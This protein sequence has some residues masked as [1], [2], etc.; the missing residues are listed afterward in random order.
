MTLTKQNARLHADARSEAMYAECQNPTSMPEKKIRACAGWV[1]KD[2]FFLQLTIDDSLVVVSRNQSAYWLPYELHV[3]SPF[4]PVGMAALQ[5]LNRLKDKK[6]VERLVVQL[7]TWTEETASEF[8]SPGGLSEV[9]FGPTAAHA[10]AEELSLWLLDGTRVVVTHPNAPIVEPTAT[11]KPGYGLRD[12]VAT[13]DLEQLDRLSFPEDGPVVIT[14][15]AGT[16]KTTVALYRARYLLEAQRRLSAANPGAPVFFRERECLVVLRKE[17][18]VPYIRELAGELMIPEVNV[19]SFDNWFRREVFRRYYRG[20]DKAQRYT[21]EPRLNWARW[22]VPIDRQTIE[23]FVAA[24]L[25]PPLHSTTKGLKVALVKEID[26]QIRIAGGSNKALGQVLDRL[27]RTLV[28]LRADTW[29]TLA[30]CEA[31]HSR[32]R[33]AFERAEALTK[34]MLSTAHRMAV[35]RQLTKWRARVVSNEQKT[36]RQAFNIPT[37]VRKFYGSDTYDDLLRGQFSDNEVA[38]AKRE[39]AE[40]NRAI[41]PCDHAAVCWLAECLLTHDA[42]SSS[43]FFGLPRYDHV[44]IDEAQFYAETT[45][46]LLSQLCRHPRRAISIVGDLDQR[47][48]DERR[49]RKWEDLVEGTLKGRVFEL[50]RIYR[51]SK[52][53]YAFLF[54]LGQSIEVASHMDHPREIDRFST[55]LPQVLVGKTMRD[56]VEWIAAEIDALASQ[57][58]LSMVTVLPR[59]RCSDEYRRQLEAELHSLGIA[60]RSAQGED[61]RECTDRMMITDPGSVV[62]LEFDIVVIPGV[63]SL[64]GDSLSDDQ[65]SAL[66][67]SATRAKRFLFLSA[68]QALPQWLTRLPADSYAL[69]NHG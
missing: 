69:T 40:V 10:V 34:F 57:G 1:S 15:T 51:C 44:I 54:S 14:G 31:W 3:A 68:R 8:Q 12:V 43:S 4:S 13:L 7:P 66:W 59:G 35:R 19:I 26:E 39:M 67:V 53:L 29:S 65:T 11:P 37:A 6:G 38:R 21:E 30:E 58:D 45:L 52:E 5:K 60:C 48:G 23:N 62:G 16:G 27:R 17:H 24:E 47:L 41:H 56:E 61:M 49:W 36:R 2:P 42:S 63:D 18:L 25:L 46:G 50:S 28:R 22:T 32:L 33:D 55:R 20:K 64:W 9:A